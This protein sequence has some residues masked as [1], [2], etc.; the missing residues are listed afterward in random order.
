MG[1]VTISPARGCLCRSVHAVAEL[2]SDSI[3]LVC[4]ARAAP[5]WCT[6]APA[7][8]AVAAA[9]QGPAAVQQQPAAQRQPLPRGA[10]TAAPAQASPAELP[11]TPSLLATTTMPHTQVSNAKKNALTFCWMELL[12]TV[13]A[14]AGRAAASP[15][16]WCTECIITCIR[17]LL[18]SSQQLGRCCSSRWF[19]GGVVCCH[20]VVFVVSVCRLQVLLQLLCQEADVPVEQLGAGRSLQRLLVGVNRSLRCSTAISW[21]ASGAYVLL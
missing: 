2:S 15:S 21:H 19:V 6:V 7:A 20:C 17:R 14:V 12:E 3:C 11:L 16:T 18:E 9:A 13:C 1:H 5:A 8:P 10:H 4:H